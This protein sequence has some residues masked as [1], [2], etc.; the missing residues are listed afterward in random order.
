VYYD[1]VSE[2]KKEIPVKWGYEAKLRG[3][4][5]RQRLMETGGRLVSGKRATCGLHCQIGI[6]LSFLTCV[7]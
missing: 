1:A 2:I 4:G 3:S 5:L 7:R 6:P